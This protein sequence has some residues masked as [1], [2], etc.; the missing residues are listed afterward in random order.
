MTVGGVWETPGYTYSTKGWEVNWLAWKFSNKR[1]QLIVTSRMNKTFD[2]KNWSVLPTAW[3]RDLGIPSISHWKLYWS[4]CKPVTVNKTVGQSATRFWK[5]SIRAESASA[6]QPAALDIY[7]RWGS[8]TP[9]M[10]SNQ[11]GVNQR[12][13][14]THWGPRRI[15]SLLP[16]F[17][18]ARAQAYDLHLAPPMAML[19]TQC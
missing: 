4:I 15:Q 12:S 16:L 14:P 8:I 3:L 7:Q 18:V 19:Y 10:G 17:L 1:T 6:M 13:N 2:N 5:L 9:C 11:S